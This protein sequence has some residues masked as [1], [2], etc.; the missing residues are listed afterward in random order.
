MQRLLIFQSLWAMERRHTDGHERSLD[1]NTAAISEAGFDGISAHYTNRHDVVRLNEA[2]RAPLTRSPDVSLAG[3]QPVESG[4]RRGTSLI[5]RLLTEEHVL[6]RLTDVV[7]RFGVGD[8][9]IADFRGSV[10][11]KDIKRCLPACPDRSFADPCLVFG[12]R[13]NGRARRGNALKRQA[14]LDFRAGGPLDEVPGGILLR[15]VMGDRQPPADRRRNRASPAGS[16]MT[17]VSARR[18]PPSMIVRN[19]LEDSKAIAARP[20]R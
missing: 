7:A 10:G 17:S 12:V 14:L 11:G 6:D 1:E 20:L 3:N 4:V 16:G 13:R 2:V 18:S 19:S 9:R 15:A 5:D 8:D